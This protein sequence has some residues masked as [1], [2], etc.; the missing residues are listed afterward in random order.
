[1]RYKKIKLYLHHELVHEITTNRPKKSVRFFLLLPFTLLYRLSYGV[2]LGL[3]FTAYSLKLVW[4]WLLRNLR[5]KTFD[6]LPLR[7]R[8]FK[9]SFAVFGI[10]VMTGALLM[11]AGIAISN[12]LSLQGQILGSTTQGIAQLKQAQDSLQNQ[13]ASLAQSQFSSALAHF[14]KAQADLNTTGGILQTFFNLIPQKQDADAVLEA[15]SDITNAGKT[16]TEAYQLINMVS[17]SAQG[18]EIGAN[19]AE[20]LAIFSNKLSEALKLVHSADEKLESVSTNSI[21]GD[22]RL[23]FLQARDAVSLTR[24]TLDNFS[25]VYRLF[26]QIIKGD[27]RFLVFFQNNN[28]LRPTGGFLGTY[29]DL[30]VRDG[31]IRKMTISSIYD[32]DGQLD[33]VITPPQQLLAVNNRWYLRDSNWFFDFPTSARKMISFYEKEGGE[34]PDLVMALTPELIIEILKVTGPIPMPTYGV[35]LSSENFIETTQLVTSIQYDREINKPKQMLADFFPLMLQTIS[36]LNLEQ[37]LRTLEIFQQSFTKKQVQLYSPNG[38]LQSNIESFG[39]GGKISDT[40]RDYL[41]IVQT[42][43]GGTKTDQYIKNEL[44]LSTEIAEDGGVINTLVLTRKNTLLQSDSMTNTSYLKFFVPQGSEL[45]ETSG[46]SAFELPTGIVTGQIDSDIAAIEQHTSRSVS[47]GTYI[48]K[49]NGKSTFGNWLITKG[50]E[51]K[52][53]TLKYR[54]PFTLNNVD[55]YSIMFQRQSGTIPIVV[56]HS[57]LALKRKVLWILNGGYE[58]FSHTLVSEFN[59]ESDAFRGI[60]F[61]K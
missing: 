39:W 11:Q 49:E 21:P 13:Q 47:N 6:P 34:T 53:V 46:F 14:Q 36:S 38:E 15:I 44:E 24:K 19:N 9:L 60:I 23:L 4:L 45:I 61:E 43:L 58:D 32:L 26:E 16:L 40:D 31:N 22:N 42:N 37:K 20:S 10:C 28:E 54:L 5:K 56:K 35:T 30:L 41:A 2:G 25:E 50:G 59:L 17:F 55:R 57:V 12:G 51:T 18:L 1:M 29:G 48:G 3:I 27:K 33:E 7:A 52:Q 8:E